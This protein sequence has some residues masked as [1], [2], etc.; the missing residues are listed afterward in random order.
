MKFGVSA[1]KMAKFHAVV[2]HAQSTKKVAYFSFFFHFFFLKEKN[3]SFQASSVTWDDRKHWFKLL[4][5]KWTL[6][7]EMCWRLC[8]FPLFVEDRMSLAIPQIQVCMQNCLLVRLIKIYRV[9][10]WT[11]WYNQSSMLFFTIF[12]RVWNSEL[13]HTTRISKHP[14]RAIFLSKSFEWILFVQI[15]VSI[16]YSFPLDW[17][18][19]RME[20]VCIFFSSGKHAVQHFMYTNTYLHNIR[21]GLC[22]VGDNSSNSSI[23]DERTSHLIQQICSINELLPFMLGNLTQMRAFYVA[24]F[25][26]NTFNINSQNKI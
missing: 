17:L 15:L 14:D 23:H 13:Q 11:T 20:L 3:K 8:I 12:A 1:L 18:S 22:V 26:V 7:N 10:L 16:R 9:T 5:V 21:L 6:Q 19:K 24:L 4:F 25:Y 2:T